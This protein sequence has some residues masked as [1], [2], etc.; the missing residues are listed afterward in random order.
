MQL[1]MP[2]LPHRVGD[3]RRGLAS[4]GGKLRGVGGPQN[5]VLSIRGLSARVEGPGRGS[6]NEA[7][8]NGILSLPNMA[9]PKGSTLKD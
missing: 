4:L 1:N 9:Q 2:Q 3:E 7:L 6:P 5:S 8:H